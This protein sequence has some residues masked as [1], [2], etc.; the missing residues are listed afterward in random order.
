M[1]NACGGSP[2]LHS[3]YVSIQVESLVMEMITEGEE[4]SVVRSRGS[5]LI[6]GHKYRVSPFMVQAPCKGPWWFGA[7][8]SVDSIRNYYIPPAIDDLVK[9]LK[10][11][12]YCILCGSRQ[13]GK[14][15]SVL[16]A[17]DRIWNESH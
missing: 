1:W 2:G 9:D 4:L 6:A 16:A 13:S 15:T 3:P 8:V 12:K 14:S 11:G 5:T 10:E 7:G 17:I